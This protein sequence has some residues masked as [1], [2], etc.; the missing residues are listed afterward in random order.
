M[1]NTA[2][3][4]LLANGIARRIGAEIGD[5]K[6]DA[7]AELEERMPPVTVDFL[8][9]KLST[10]SGVA[11]HSYTLTCRVIARCVNAAS[12][13]GVRRHQKL[14]CNSLSLAD[15]SEDWR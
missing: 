4:I 6:V 13:K 3:A 15:V 8:Q 10:F 14:R 7:L 5:R 1:L 2:E 11:R 9:S 12:S